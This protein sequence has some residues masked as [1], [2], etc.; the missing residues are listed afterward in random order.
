MTLIQKATARSRPKRE[1][2]RR[3]KKT[4]VGITAP[5]PCCKSRVTGPPLAGAGHRR[6]LRKSPEITD[7]RGWRGVDAAAPK[8][9]SNQREI[10]REGGRA[11][12]TGR[13]PAAPKP[14][15]TD[16][17]A[18][19]QAG[20]RGAGAGV[21]VET[22]SGPEAT[23]TEG[24]AEQQMGGAEAGRGE[25]KERP[26]EGAGAERGG[27]EAKTELTENTD[28][29]VS[30]VCHRSVISSADRCSVVRLPLGGRSDQEISMSP[31]ALRRCENRLIDSQL[32]LFPPVILNGQVLDPI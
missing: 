28:P 3:R 8:M 13:E 10:K 27:I 30:R 9:R 7:R 17:G 19:R 18:A 12:G 14:P 5:R 21:T 32:Q 4:H 24:R 23:Q 29:S 15:R 6:G 2:R 22:L 25:K 31:A 11:A 20:R 1:R 16:A 26:G